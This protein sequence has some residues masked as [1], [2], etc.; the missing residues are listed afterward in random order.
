MPELFV[1]AGLK[2]AK[3]HLFLCVGPECCEPPEGERAWE[4]L[5][6]RVKETGAEV[7]R[8]RAACLR[9][10][11]GGPWLVVYP[12]GV[13]YGQ[14]TPARMEVILERHILGGQPVE[15]WIAV[16]TPCGERAQT[17]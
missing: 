10:C 6:R 4:N 7:M 11:S 15:E 16:R 8:T 3:R 5:K 13:W 17:P 9:V 2:N 14:V 12:E 1:R